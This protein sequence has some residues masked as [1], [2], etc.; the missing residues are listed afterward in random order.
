M[1]LGISEGVYSRIW[2]DNSGDG[3]MSIVEVVFQL[4][5]DRNLRALVRKSW[6][7]AWDFRC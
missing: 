1:A 2:G 5:R 7:L 6:L 4:E 3:E